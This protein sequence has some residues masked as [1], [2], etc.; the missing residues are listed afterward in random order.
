LVFSV[1]S[2]EAHDRL[3]AAGAQYYAMQ[4]NSLPESVKIASDSL[5]I[6][7]VTSFSTTE[8]DVDRFVVIAQG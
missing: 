3:Q 1:I 5:L 6:R 2:R 7:L 4:S 8:A